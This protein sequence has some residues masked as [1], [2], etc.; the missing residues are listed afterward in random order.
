MLNKLKQNRNKI[1]EALTIAQTKDRI[2]LR[3]TEYT[4]A[5]SLEQ[6]GQLA[7]AIVHYEKA[8]THR[9]DVPRMLIDQQEQLEAY[10]SKTNDP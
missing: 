7:E 10:M 1:D 5:R 8:N 9:Y 3:N 2:H 4:Y 6:S